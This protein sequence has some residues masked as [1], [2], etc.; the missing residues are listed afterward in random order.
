MGRDKSVILPCYNEADNISLIL[1]AFS[2]A[3]SGRKDIEVVLVDNGSTDHTSKMLKENHSKPEYSFARSVS[4]KIN[5]GYGFGILAG[6][7]SCESE[8]LGW[9]H[10][11]MQTPPADVLRGFDQ[12]VNHDSQA[13]LKGRR[14]GRNLFDTFFTWGMSVFSSILL[15]VRLSDINAQPKLFSRTFLDSFKNPP[16]DF[17]LDLFLLFLAR[18][19]NTPI[20]EM[21]VSFKSRMYGEAK[22]GG[23]LYGKL[24]II[25]R[26]LICIKRLKA[27]ISG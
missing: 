21:D 25:Q 16:H 18:K 26:T 24:R 12:L 17:A 22:G 1:E 20:L 13:V 11:D 2:E 7:N 5:Q 6:L 9:T 8:W 15:R 10:A 4:V 3:L 27:S 14:R 19:N 23:S